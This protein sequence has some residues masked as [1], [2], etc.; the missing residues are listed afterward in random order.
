MLSNAR[1]HIAMLLKGLPARSATGKAALRA[2]LGLSNFT[3]LS[4][5]PL[6]GVC[7]GFSGGRVAGDF[8]VGLVF[9]PGFGQQPDPV[10]EPALVHQTAQPIDAAPEYA[11]LPF[12]LLPT[13]AM[14][15]S[16]RLGRRPQVAWGDPAV[17]GVFRPGAVG[18]G[19]ERRHRKHQPVAGDADI[20]GAKDSTYTLVEADK[21]R[22]IKV[23]VT[24]TDDAGNEE[25]LTSSATTEVT[26][27]AMEPGSL[28]GFTVVD[29]SDQTVV[30]ALT[31]GS[32]LTLEDP[33]SGS[34]GIRVD[35]DPDVE[36]GSV[37]LEL[38]GAKTVSQTENYAPYSLYGDDADGL[39]GEG[40]P[41]G[42][43]TLRATAYSEK[44]LSGDDLG[45]LEVSFTVADSSSDPQDTPENTPA[46]G[47]P[48]IS[49]TVQV[50]ETLTADTSAVEDADGLGNAVFE[51]QWI[52]EDTEVA[53][54]TSSTYAPVDADVGKTIKVRVTF[55]DEGSNPESLTSTATAPVA[56]AADETEPPGPIWSAILTVG[57]TGEN[58]GYQSFLNPQV[59][60]LV[61]A[62]FVL[63]D[64]TYTVGS[65]QTEADYFTVF[66]VDR[67]L[68]VGFTLEVDG[69][70]FESSDASSLGSHTYGHVY[71][72][73]GRGMDWDVGEEV[74]VSLILRERVE[75]TP[76]TGAPAI[77]GTAQVGRT[78]SADTSGISDADGLGS[79]VFE[80][81]WV[82]S[83][84]TTDT[85][86]AGATDSTYALVD[87]DEGATIK[88]RVS[89]TD[90]GGNPE[91]QTS[92]A[93]ATVIDAL[94]PA[95]LKAEQQN[96]GVILSWAGPV[97]GTEPVT[98][99]EIRRTLEH[100]SD[101]IERALLIFIDGTETQWLDTLA[102][103]SGVYTYRVTARRG[104]GPSVESIVQIE[105]E[106]ESTLTPENEPSGPLEFALLHGSE[107]DSIVLT[108][109]PPR[110]R[111]FDGLF[112]GPE[113][114]VDG[115][116][117]DVTTRLASAVQSTRQVAD[118]GSTADTWTHEHVER[119]IWRRYSIRGHKNG[120]EGRAAYT[121][122]VRIPQAGEPGSPSNLRLSQQ[123]DPTEV[124]LNWTAGSDATGYKIYRR[125][126]WHWNDVYRVNELHK[127]VGLEA[128]NV[129]TYTDGD[130]GSLYQGTIHD[131]DNNPDTTRIIEGVLPGFTYTY[132][133][134]A[135][136]AS[137]TSAGLAK[138]SILIPTPGKPNAVRNFEHGAIRRGNGA[139]TNIRLSWDAPQGFT[140]NR[141]G[142]TA[143][144]VIERALD[145]ADHTEQGRD[146]ENLATVSIGT[147]TYT[148]SA[149]VDAANADR[150]MPFGT[151]WRY[152][153]RAVSGSP[154]KQ[155][156]NSYVDAA[157]PMP[158]GVPGVISADLIQYGGAFA[159]GYATFSIDENSFSCARVKWDHDRSGSF[160]TNNRILRLGPGVTSWHDPD[161]VLLSSTTGLAH[162][163]TT[164]I[165]RLAGAGDGGPNAVCDTTVEA[166]ETYIYIVQA[167]N[168]NGWNTQV[169][170]EFNVIAT[171]GVIYIEVP[172]SDAPPPPTEVEQD[173][174]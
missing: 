163:S 99:Y 130:A 146:W 153:I 157:I 128:G 142:G 34:Y 81:Q 171:I 61:P 78:L 92:A 160:P 135:V 9:G 87:A 172:G 22:S 74:A 37:R 23:L 40:M 53:G 154:T 30:G 39:H 95:N 25:T 56:P 31:A 91:S 141:F 4:A 143:S 112:T 93:T 167:R 5:P 67:E 140:T 105:I 64:V 45:A 169:V 134:E 46:T 119:G 50:G 108:W 137:G 29:A 100:T 152:R 123:A 110:Q 86:I 166:G 88:V 84:G 65:I 144:Y 48:T 11:D 1:S 149:A 10:P 90:G 60:S 8:Q 126:S 59:G 165:S 111:G 96:D 6:I 69:A 33:A 62:T 132:V 106:G 82:R 58:Y 44:S 151:T 17:M 170:N 43:Y 113:V 101:G 147:H 3:P 94:L 36:I 21:D 26:A 158:S 89:F 47:Q 139:T 63:D 150:I 20:S 80:Y 133:V 109:S 164:N 124:R 73:L 103:E 27:A 2:V 16:K 174:E 115:Y 136:N 51:Y 97:D 38:M 49:G 131:D 19:Q 57:R 18:Q 75:N 7:K 52:A 118:L 85:D 104:D 54:A 98:G 125:S 28:T 161:A 71:T 77:S 32:T 14:L 159:T 68:P 41:A 117:I 127:G 138:A 114:D 35:T 122:W 72:W 83:D 24:F 107:P 168:N 156:D 55:T 70:Q 148:D 42:A 120:D 102:G 15:G 162:Q 66:G 116:L 145:L 76:Q 155:S 13:V 173:E 121:D 12:R 79:G 129:T